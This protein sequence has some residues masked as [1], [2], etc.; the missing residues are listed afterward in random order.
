MRGGAPARSRGPDHQE[1][2]RAHPLGAQGGA[3]DLSSGAV[4]AVDAGDT[5]TVRE[6]VCEAGEQMRRWQAGRR[7][8]A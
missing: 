6:T 2:I 5:R 3:V 7:A 4:V 8:R 1:E